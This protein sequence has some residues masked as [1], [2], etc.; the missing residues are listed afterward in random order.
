MLASVKGFD[1]VCPYSMENSR[2]VVNKEWV[3][4]H[5]LR[6]ILVEL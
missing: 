4:K 2:V 3:T 1:A 5:A 6:V